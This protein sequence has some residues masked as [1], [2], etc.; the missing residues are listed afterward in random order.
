[1]K[2]VKEIIDTNSKKFGEFSY[3]ELLIDKVE[4]NLQ[5]NPDIAIEASKALIEGISKTILISLD[6]TLNEN[7]L[8]EYNL[9]KLFKDTL[10]K[11]SEYDE[12]FEIEFISSFRHTVKLIGEIRTHRGDIAHGKP[13]PKILVSS[14]EIATFI[15]GTTSSIIV[16]M[17]EH[18]F[19]LEIQ[20]D[21]NISYIDNKKFNLMLDETV[22]LGFIKYS[23]ALYSQDYNS[24]TEQLKE[25]NDSVSEVDEIV[26]TEKDSTDIS[27]DVDAKVEE[28]VIK[29]NISE[30]IDKKYSELLRNTTT[31]DA[32]LVL[33]QTEELYINEVLKVI[34]T[35][36]FDKRLPLSSEIVN[37][38]KVKPK[39]L[40]RKEVVENTTKN[41][42]KFVNEY[43]EQD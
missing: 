28:Q 18:F 24:Y 15:V 5:K 27:E 40:K 22:P 1:M 30:D 36:L 2:L 17:L 38:L 7:D 23:N 34:D 19:S 41:I 43:I 10:L 8:K 26:S 21:E 25:F 4:S 9:P 13:V 14:L 29:Q 32:L 31:Q 42:L 11:I 20:Y 39:L 16:Y 12:T 33:C 37:L 3:Y 6:N 35:Y